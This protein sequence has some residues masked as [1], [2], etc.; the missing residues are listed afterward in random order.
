MAKKTNGPR[1]PIALNFLDRLAFS[2]NPVRGARRIAAR[3]YLQTMQNL[4]YV[5]GGDERRSM[6][7]WIT[8][9]KSADDTLLPELATIRSRCRD[10]YN[11]TP[12]A[13]GAI[14]RAKTNTVGSGLAL[15]ALINRQILE[16]E[17][18]A[19]DEWER[20]TEQRFNMWASS[21]D[22]DI[23]RTQNFYELQGLAFV[24]TLLGGDCFALLPRKKR[25]GMDSDLRIAIF[26]G[27][28]VS[29]P[30]NALDTNGLA[31]G[32][33]LDADGA[34]KAYHFSNIHPNSY[35]GQQIEWV[36]VPA[37]GEKSKRR[38]VIH[39]FNRERPGGR[40]G[41]PFL[42]S[43]VDSL[44]QL[45]RYSE[46]ELMAAVV[47]AFFTVF[48]KQSTK[49][50]DPLQAAIA[51]EQKITNPDD[52]SRPQDYATYEMGHGNIIGLGENEE[53]DLAASK[54]PG[55]NFGPF[56]EAVVRQIGSA[57]EIP[58]E[59][60]ILHFTASYSAA[61]AALLEAWKFYRHARIWLARNFCQ[62]IYEEW[63]YEEIINNRIDAP[64]FLENNFKRYAWLQSAWIGSGMGQI[65][66]VKESKAAALKLDD[67]LT[68]YDTEYS[69]IYG[70]DWEAM[71]RRRQRQEKYIKSL[72]LARAQK[73][74][75]PG[76]GNPDGDGK[77]EDTPEE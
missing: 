61:R 17:D 12:I 23:T 54:H 34:P 20:N 8:D 52:T 26:E 39:L 64:G 10:L 6:R 37:Y 46:A 35:T 77:T 7:G 11:N 43:V 48:V 3:A 2:I 41:V 9:D 19:A 30:N 51:T 67:L 62:L 33:E 22:C 57:L 14:K 36:K 74:A 18:D 60:L 75:A 4:G 73:A 76:A 44:K 55:S 49:Q 68:D 47:Q 38:Q 13:T 63:L 53:I 21:K 71:L 42:H 31:A 1:P 40:R 24:S 28:F 27:D 65:D 66:P 29:N 25:E 50:N 32:I 69:L 72:N 70:G 56:F 59:Q 5:A 15:Q 16:L 58:F 45:G